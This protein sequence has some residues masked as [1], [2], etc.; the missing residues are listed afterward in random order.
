MDLY[1]NRNPAFTNWVVTSGLL[2]ES[3]VVVDIGCQGGEHPRWQ[4]L[5]NHLELHSFDA[6]AEV[7]DELKEAN[8]AHSNKHYYQIAIGDK[9][10]EK[11]FVVVKDNPYESSF[12]ADPNRDNLEHRRVAVRT[13]DSLFAEGVIG[14]ADFMKI[15]IE[16]YEVMALRSASN[17]LS[18][19]GLLGAEV[20]TSLGVS[21]TYPR[22]QLVEICDLLIPHRFLFADLAHDNWARPA[23]QDLLRQVHGESNVNVRYGVPATFN[24]L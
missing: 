18:S 16:A 15:D 24:V 22:T 3:F 5:Q 8:A 12:Y 9:D 21:P 4:S 7:I 11:E 23:A 20:E 2:Q 13:L 14:P 6:L 10:G 17:F 1:W 19:A